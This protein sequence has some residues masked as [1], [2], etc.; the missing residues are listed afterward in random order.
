MKEITSVRGIGEKT[1]EKFHRLSVYTTEDLLSHYP[2]TYQY[3]AEPKPLAEWK[4]GQTAVIRGVVT[5][6]PSVVGRGGRTILTVSVSDGS[7][8]AVCRFFS[9]PYL[10]NRLPLGA[11]YVF[12]GKLNMRGNTLYLEHPEMFSM[13]EYE[14]RQGSYLPVYP[15][16]AGLSQNSVSKAVRAALEEEIPADYLS[17]DFRRRLSLEEYGEAIR[18]IH[19][20][21]SAEDIAKARKRLVFDEFF[22]FAL[23]TRLQ[24]RQNLA[25]PNGFPVRVRENTAPELVLKNLPYQLTGAQLRAWQDIVKDLEGPCRMNRLVQGD[26]GSGK[27]ILAF[28]AMLA[29]TEAGFQAAM[30]APTEVLAR[31][32]Y[33]GI[34]KLLAEQG[35]SR[36]VELLTGSL[37]AKEKREAQARIRQGLVDIVIGTQALIQEKVH[38]QGLGLVVTDE[39]HRFG[40]RQREIFAKKA[41]SR[42]DK[43]SDAELLAEDNLPHVLV[44]SATPIPRTLALIL[45]ADLNVS[46]IDELPAS[47]LPIKNCVVKPDFQENACRFIEKEMKAGHQAY[48]ICPMVEAGEEDGELE[49]VTERTETLKKRF[50]PNFHVEMLHGKM[51]PKEK[52]EIMERFLAHDIDLLVSTTVVEVG[53]NVPNATVMVVENADHFGLAQLH[54]LRGRV[55]RG[56]SQSYCIFL[57]HSDEQPFAKRLEIL[58]RSN[59]GFEIAAEDLKLRGPG[60]L[61]GERQSGEFVF[62]L[63]DIYADQK[64]LHAAS[65]AAGALLEQ[66]PD[67]AFEEHAAL[68]RK[69]VVFSQKAFEEAVL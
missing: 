41:L 59:D 19:F 66:D 22:L 30:M 17:A 2:R 46:V 39:Q 32:H 10:K 24:R 55:G 3:Y 51:K 14:E 31:Q 12:R 50:E 57:D 18:H 11:R 63:G 8:T 16:T 13:A 60:E 28:L 64:E 5:R 4:S 43:D 61:F 37:T 34:V 49:N 62:K 52:N 54:Q 67:L 29:V 42:Q 53:V 27:T 48:Y 40:V 7:G 36:R 6:S 69:L 9:M 33:E 20:P 21:E 1:A 56:K 44:M 35:I 47:R 23:A 68:R 15:L 26:V 58:N 25:D 38:F 65:E 45:Y